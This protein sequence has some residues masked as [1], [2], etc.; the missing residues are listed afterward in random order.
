MGGMDSLMVESS[1]VEGC[2]TR[3]TYPRI[4]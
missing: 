1:S 2:W 4:P 3:A